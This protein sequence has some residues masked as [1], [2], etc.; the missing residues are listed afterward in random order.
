MSAI[1]SYRNQSIGGDD[2]ACEEMIPCISCDA[3]LSNLD[4][5]CHVCYTPMEVSQ[6]VTARDVQPDFISVLGA[7]NAGKTVYLGL[8][9]DMLGNRNS[10]IRGSAQG[11][12]SISLQEH[13][14]NAL[15]QC[16][17]P[18]KTP[19]E[20]DLWKWLH[21]ELTWAESKKIS[22]QVDF[23]APDVAGEAVA[24]EL[25][26]AGL[27]PAIR[28]VVSRSSGILLL[29]DSAEVRDAG[30]REDLFAMKIGSYITDLNRSLGRGKDSSL[31]AI[32]VV[33]TKSDTC[34]EAEEC[35]IRFAQHNMPRFVDFCERK[36]PK[37]Q[38]FAA[39]VIGASCYVNDSDLGH[40]N[41]PLHIQ[42][43]GVIEPLQ[44]LVTQC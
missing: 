32:A 21:C 27:Y 41:V 25:E 42:P 11:T 12:F 15:Q 22:K 4:P 13:V 31:P 7:S 18:E 9:L 20:C 2:E 5:C 6:S 23:I 10:P 3:E 28:H 35:P 39:S 30:P 24:G 26:Q 33:F 36:L 19:T 14:V 40:R 34:P 43:R 1:Q 17:F 38:Y 8:L 37:H 44:W 16:R 29:C